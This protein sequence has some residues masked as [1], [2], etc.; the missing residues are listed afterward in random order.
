MNL[1][2]WHTPHSHILEQLFQLQWH[3]SSRNAD[4]WPICSAFP[5]QCWQWNIALSN[6]CLFISLKGLC[7]CLVSVARGITICD[8]RSIPTQVFSILEIPG[9]KLCCTLHVKRDHVSSS[10]FPALSPVISINS[11]HDDSDNVPSVSL[12]SRAIF[13]LAQIFYPFLFPSLF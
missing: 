13:S 1:A 4:I 12:T 2:L 5:L 7:S 3:L 6:N 11:F 8:T 10:S 9:W